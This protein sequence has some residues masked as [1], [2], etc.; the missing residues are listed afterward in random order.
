[1]GHSVGKGGQTMIE[2]D[3]G[4]DE[5]ADYESEEGWDD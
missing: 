2:F 3:L 1:M 5:T 4:D